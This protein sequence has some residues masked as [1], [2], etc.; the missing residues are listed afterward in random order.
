R[1]VLTNW[2]HPKRDSVIYCHACNGPLVCGLEWRFLRPGHGMS[3]YG[4]YVDEHGVCRWCGAQTP[5]IGLTPAEHDFILAAGEAGPIVALAEPIVA[6]VAAYHG[7]QGAHQLARLG[8][9]Q[10]IALR[11]V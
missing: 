9:G 11:P 4:L 2:D 3:N 8:E 10:R 5:I 7:D 1:Y 6:A